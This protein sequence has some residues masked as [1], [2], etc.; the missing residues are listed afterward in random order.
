MEDRRSRSMCACICCCC[1]IICLHNKEISN[2]SFSHL[3]FNC[4]GEQ[5]GQPAFWSITLFP[6]WELRVRFADFQKSSY[7][8][9]PPFIC[10]SRITSHAQSSPHASA[11]HPSAPIRAPLIFAPVPVFQLG[12][13]A[14]HDSGGSGERGKRQVTGRQY[15]FPAVCLRT[16][17]FSQVTTGQSAGIKPLSI[18]VL[19]SDQEKTNI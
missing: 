4:P 1:S 19:L 11:L 17:S 9:L 8:L 7:A 10:N 16:K 3:S 6:V 14:C 18:T 15:D 2:I 12:P 5:G 13:H